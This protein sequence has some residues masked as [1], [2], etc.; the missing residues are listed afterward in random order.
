MFILNVCSVYQSFMILCVSLIGRLLLGSTDG[1]VVTYGVAAN[2]CIATAY[3][4]ASTYGIAATFRVDNRKESLGLHLS[5][6]TR[7]TR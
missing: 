1:V 3:G 6:D 4:V 7:V 2:Y 5:S